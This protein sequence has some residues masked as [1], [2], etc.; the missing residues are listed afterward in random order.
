MRA[1]IHAGLHKTGT[2]SFQR[3]CYDMHKELLKQQIHYPYVKGLAHHNRFVN[4]V[5]VNWLKPLIRTTH[6]KTGR[7]GCLLISAENLEY[8]LYTDKPERIEKTLYES[9]ITN[10]IWVLCFREPFAAYRSLY[11]QLSKSGHKFTTTR[12]ILEFEAGGQMISAQG[13][14]STQNHRSIQSFHFNYPRLIQD[15]RQRLNGTVV[16]VNFKDF[17]QQSKA[18]GDLL[19]RALS[20]ERKGLSDLSDNLPTHELR[21]PSTEQIERNFVHRFFAFD[22]TK[23]GNEPNYIKQAI[24]TR[25]ENRLNSEQNIKRLFKTTFAGWDQALTP[26]EELQKLLR[27]PAPVRFRFPAAVHGL[28][29]FQT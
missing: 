10:V 4:Q 9:G 5:E 8:D 2:S 20:T 27:A 25:L 13:T 28:Q 14:L 21:S 16:G 29:F 11:A 23:H 24:H 15:L 7:N 22:P 6:K 26:T 12:A 17:T 19:I 18:P 1:V 3:C